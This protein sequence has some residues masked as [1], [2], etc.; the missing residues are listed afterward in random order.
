MDLPPWVLLLII[1]AIIGGIYIIFFA[2]SSSL[3]LKEDY[4]EFKIEPNADLSEIKLALKK[5]EVKLNAIEQELVSNSN[6]IKALQ[7]G[8]GIRAEQLGYLSGTTNAISSYFIDKT[9]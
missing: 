4:S 1:V 5:N 2:P 6:K 9:P 8:Q 3:N 7:L